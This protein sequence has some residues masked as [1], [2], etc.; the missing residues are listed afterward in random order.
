MLEYEI[1]EIDRRLACLVQQ[2][3]VDAVSYD[4]PRCRVRVGDWV[5]DWLPWFTVAACAVRFWRPPS[6]G[7]QASVLSASGEL[8]SA[9]AVPGYYAEQ[10]G[11]AAR[12]SPNE[13]AFDFPDGASQVYDHASHEYR[14]DVP[15]GGRIVFRIGETELELRADGVTLRTEKLLGDI[16]DSTFTGNTTTEQ[17][18]TFNGGMQGKAGSSVGLAV[19]VSGGAAFS[20][21]IVAS[22]TS[23]SQHRHMEQGDGAPTSQPL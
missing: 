9:Y 13:T 14:V 7:E 8:S 10:H 16:P 4:P 22:G 3:T 21:D 19:V 15:A 20:D 1:G 6:E 17:R 11:G 2:G 5:S 23:V 12:R 18:L